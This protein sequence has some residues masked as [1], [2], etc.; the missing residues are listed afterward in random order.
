[1]SIVVS[2]SVFKAQALAFVRK[3]ERTGEP[4]VITHHGKPVLTLAP[5]REEPA[6]S[7]RVLRDSV[8]RYDGPFEP[9]S[10]EDWESG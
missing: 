5:Y 10:D 1:M 4:I 3:V 2:K 9:V 7:L 6:E 8:V